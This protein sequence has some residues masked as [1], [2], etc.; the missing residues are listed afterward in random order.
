MQHFLVAVFVVAL[1]SGGI[2]AVAGFGVGSLLTP[3]L[4]PYLGVKLAVAAVALPHLAG[5][6]LR[7]WLLWGHIDWRVLRTFGVASAAGGLLGAVLYTYA[8][9]A[10]LTLLLAVL[11]IF[12]GLMGVTGQDKHLRFGPRWASLVGVVSG[13]L[14]ALVGNQGRDS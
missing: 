10:A 4:L 1:V 12:A 3:L 8:H 11:L 5:V 13:A 7:M 6:A 14:G 9:H 2:A